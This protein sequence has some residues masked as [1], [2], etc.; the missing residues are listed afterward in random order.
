MN[1]IIPFDFE[2]HRDAV[3]RLDDGEKG[4]GIGAPPL[5]QLRAGQ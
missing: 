3:G 1:D 4:V 2:N 5:A